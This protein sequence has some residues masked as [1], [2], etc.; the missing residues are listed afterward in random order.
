MIN[1]PI[2]AIETIIRR[3]LIEHPE[4]AHGLTELENKAF[5]VN[6][7][8]WHWRIFVQFDQAGV[9]IG[10]TPVE[11]DADI[12]GDPFDLLALLKT[13]QSGSGVNISGDLHLVQKASDWFKQLQIDWEAVFVKT[14]GDVP[15]YMSY[16][17]A[18]RLVKGATHVFQRMAEN[19]TQFLTDDVEVIVARPAVEDFIA[20][21][22]D[23]RHAVARL[24]ARMRQQL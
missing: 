6:M 24:E 1:A 12:E 14:L 22:T 7:P 9:K 20:E 19:T 21:V 17:V 4:L 2:K 16:R 10:T 23:F 15:G 13:G 11:V 8:G 18:S 5:A 3:L